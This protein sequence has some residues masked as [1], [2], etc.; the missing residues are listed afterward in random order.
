MALLLLRTLLEGP[1]YLVTNFSAH[2]YKHNWW[3]SSK[4]YLSTR[5]LWFRR[6]ASICTASIRTASICTA[7][8]HC[9]YLNCDHS[10]CVYSHWYGGFPPVVL[11]LDP[12]QSVVPRPVQYALPPGGDGT[13]N[14]GTQC[15]PFFNKRERKQRLSVEGSRAEKKT[16]SQSNTQSMQSHTYLPTSFV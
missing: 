3:Y 11:Q 16:G 8:S 1:L 14:V 7:S 10:H 9:V 12:G 5:V 2:F 13:S 15:P 6:T 4:W